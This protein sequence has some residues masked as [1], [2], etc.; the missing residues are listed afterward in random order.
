MIGRLARKEKNIPSGK[1]ALAR[2]SPTLRRE[3]PEVS[4]WQDAACDSPGGGVNTLSRTNPML[5]RGRSETSGA[6]AEEQAI[7][8][9]AAGAPF[10]G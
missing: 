6:A 1:E 3:A 7:F 9:P 10:F 4:V 8:G 2:I 5:Q